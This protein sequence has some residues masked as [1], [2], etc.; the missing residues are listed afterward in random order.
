MGLEDDEHA[1]AAGRGPRR[2]RASRPPPAD[3]ARSRRRPAPRAASPRSS[4]RRPAPANSGSTRSAF[5]RATPATSSAARA[6]AALRRLC[7]PGAASSNV[8]GLELVPPHDLAAHGRATLEQLPHLGLR[9]E[10]RVVVELDVRQHCDPRPQQLERPV[11]LVALGDEPA[12]PRAR[13][14]GELRDLAADQEGGIEPEPVEHERDHRR[15]RRLAVCARDDD[16]GPQ[17]DELGQQLRPLLLHAR[18]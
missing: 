17:F 14:P 16:R 2:P 9:G 1:A 6:A 8:D 15:G 4:K 3:G 7:S 11:R 10:G 13:I 18:A 12:L 5:S